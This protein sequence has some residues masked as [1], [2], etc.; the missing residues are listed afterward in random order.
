MS[1]DRI[2]QVSVIM[3]NYNGARFIENAVKSV[4]GQTCSDLELIVVD[5]ASTDNSVAILERLAEKDSRLRAFSGRKLGGP[6]AARNFALQHIRGEW[7]AIVDSDDLIRPDRLARMLETAADS[8]ADIIVDDL[9]I[10]HTAGGFPPFTMF[11]GDFAQK[12]QWVGAADYVRLNCLNSAGTQLGYA[13]PMFRASLF[14]GTRY[15][16]RLR[17]GEDYELVARLLSQGS[18]LVTCPDI[19][20]FYRKH[21]ASISH[22]LDTYSLDALAQN[23]KNALQQDG[24]DKR[25]KAESRKRYKSIVVATEF[26]N[27]VA[28]FK[29]GNIFAAIG[30]CLAHPAAASLLRQPIG[31]RL[32]DIIRALKSPR[33]TPDVTVIVRQR[34]VGETN[35]SSTYLLSICRYLSE[36]GRKVTMLWPNPATFGRWPI[37]KIHSDMSFLHSTHWR[38]AVRIGNLVFS[39]KPRIYLIAAA[40]IAERA[41]LKMRILKSARI[42]PAQ[43]A[44][45]APA[46]R[47]DLTFVARHA[48]GSAA[49]IADYA[50]STPYLPFALAP[51]AAT[52]VIMHD[53]FSARAQQFKTAGASDDFGSL[54]YD[55]EIKLLSAAD[56]VVA[57]QYEEAAAVALGV[58][59]DRVVTAPMAVTVKA[60]ASIGS[61]NL[62]FFVGSQA[63]P[64]V[65]GLA[66]FFD[67]VWP[68]ILAKNSAIRIKVAGR[69][70]ETVSPIPPNVEIL[71]VVEDLAPYYEEAGVII[72]PLKTGSGLKIKLVEALAFGKAAVVT[73][74]TL[75][76]I[77]PLVNDAVC[78]AD[79]P[80]E[81]AD[82][83][84][85]L[86]VD[87]QLRKEL[88]GRSLVCAREQFSAKKTYA[89]IALALAPQLRVGPGCEG[90]FSEP[91]AIGLVSSTQP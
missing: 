74:V 60:K 61:D 13:K 89:P 5:D 6:A 82:N 72:S 12:P 7:V 46:A 81:F 80:A 27:I 28:A 49:V 88:C 35:G 11:K 63:G 51:D 77:A 62:V 85:T 32:A 16:E 45:M 8:G 31:Q 65:Y 30:L 3:A 76:G 70:G 47:D 23:A 86:L 14:A 43:S 4:L 55:D 38:D 39:L 41:L 58:G 71:G 17:I 34:I 53:F 64:N 78:A 69:V 50:F 25:L 37:L 59:P 2:P 44:L 29:R 56:T 48:Q 91:G 42:K 79:E 75:Q 68:L 40:T 1:G 9:L 54:S 84:L 20:Y 67:A 15:D 87:R 52:A 24:L 90:Q 18:R 22:R 73:P 33:P 19:M 83:I 66:W 10:F 26:A 57:I 21:D 36:Q